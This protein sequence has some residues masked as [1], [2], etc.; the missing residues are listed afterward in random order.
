MKRRAFIT[1]PAKTVG[2]L[3]AYRVIGDPTPIEAQAGDLKVPL[4]FFTAAEARTIEAACERIFPSDDSGPGA[5][6]AGVVIYIDRQLAGPYGG[7]SI[8]T[9]SLHSSSHSRNMATRARRRRASF[10]GPASV[11]SA[12]SWRCHRPDGTSGCGPSRRRISF[13]C[14]GNT[15]LRACSATRCTAATPT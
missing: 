13:A 12:T 10:T 2:M 15:Q 7:T 1:L 11:S 9:R 6:D 8:G 5:K 4:R 14:C 3:L